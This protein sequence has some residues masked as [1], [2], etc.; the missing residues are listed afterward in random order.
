[1]LQKNWPAKEDEADPQAPLESPHLGG[2]F[3]ESSHTNLLIFGE[4][5]DRF[6]CVE[7]ILQNTL[8]PFVEETVLVNNDSYRRIMT[9]NI[10]VSETVG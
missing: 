9:R 8:L 6:F 3:D 10:L 1:M 7:E 5:V 2:N 4:I